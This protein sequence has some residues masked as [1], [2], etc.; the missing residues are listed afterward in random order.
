MHLD[1]AFL[2]FGNV[3]RALAQLLLR[4]ASTLQTDYGITFNV[5]GIATHSRGRAIN[6]AGLNLGDALERVTRGESLQPLGSGTEPPDT[7]EFITRCPADLFFEATPTNPRDG[8]PA[9]SYVRT[10]LGKGAHVV[11]ANKGPVAFG[12]RELA[13]LARERGVGFFFESTVLDGA[14]AL[15]IGREGLPAAHIRRIRGVFNST[16]NYILTRMEA[17]GLDLE[18]AICEAQAIGIAETD[19]T[20]DVDGWDSAIKTVIMANVLMGADLRPSDVEPV[21]VGEITLE[22]VRQAQADGKRIR[23]ICLA[24]RDQGAVRVS[25]RPELVSLD[26]PL[27]SVSGTSSLIEY[28]TDTLHRLTVI[29]HDPGP[30]TTAYG[31]LADMVNLARGRHLAA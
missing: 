1:V 10:A 21:G 28:E 3:N 6:P 20:L 8:Q 31:L 26:D 29:E 11:S 5:V 14:P 19:P 18:A 13:A 24:E 4:K 12:Y 2:G 30:D 17:D 22:R 23:L 27:A 7:L 15:G 25:V 16:T 9:L